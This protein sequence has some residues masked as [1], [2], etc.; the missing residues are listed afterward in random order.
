MTP[1]SA[2]SERLQE[3]LS[4]FYAGRTT[5]DDTRSAVIDV[6]LDRMACARVSLWKFNGDGDDL[7][8]LCFASK[9]AG[10]TIDTT[11]G[12][13]VGSNTATTSTP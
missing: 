7:A 8:L 1:R 6:I 13:C 11:S 3:I 9:S 10:G 12:A 5:R 4:G 2:L